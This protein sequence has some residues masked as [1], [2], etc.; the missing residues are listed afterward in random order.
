[1]SETIGSKG[2]NRLP[3]KHRVGSLLA[4]LS[5]VVTGCTVGGSPQPRETVTVVGTPEANP[6]TGAIPSESKHN[7]YRSGRSE[8][9]PELTFNY[10]EGNSTTIQ[11]YPGSGF[12]D[13]DRQ[14]NGGFK[15]G[16]HFPVIC[17]EEGRPV[18]SESPEAPR[19]S[20]I[21]FK[22]HALGQEYFAT[23]VYADLSGATPPNC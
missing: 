21:W 14:S 15:D 3:A 16:E 1:M 2:K 19:K 6:N 8:G 4:G 20:D 17:Q 18:A 12:T 10:L 22:F 23:A 13:K 5:L 7:I 11:V 9:K